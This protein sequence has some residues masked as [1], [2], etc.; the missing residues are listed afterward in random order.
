MS[1]REYRL[2]KRAKQMEET[3]QRILDAGRD[4]F[5]GE[6]FH[7]VSV[8]E[9]ADRASVTRATVY[10]HFD[11]KT[12]VLLALL[13]ELERRAEIH[14]LVDALRHPDP[15]QA[16]R[17]FLRDHCRFWAADVL[18]FRNVFSLSAYDPE[19]NEAKNQKDRNRKASIARLVRR[20][21]DADRLH[22]DVTREQALDAIWL[23]THFETFD[24][25]YRSGN[26]DV[27][28]VAEILV[29]MSNSLIREPKE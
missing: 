13:E 10:N 19:L 4:L 14:R 17:E 2:G 1:K 12:G 27:E 16:L 18:V 15:V 5:T 28:E 21:A 22:P 6:G 26:L 8:S 3:R 9:I 20:L 25:L 23:L 24:F 7:Q 29:T 11:S